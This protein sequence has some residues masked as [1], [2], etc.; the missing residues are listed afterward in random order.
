M[1]RYDFAS[2][3]AVVTG[4]AGGIGEQLAYAL[5]ERGSALILVDRDG[6]RLELVAKNARTR[7]RT[8]KSVR[9]TWSISR[10]TRRPTPRPRPSPPH[11]PTSAC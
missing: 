3:T 6:E 9:P 2:G 11:T 1:E 4:A 8:G 5:A 7:M 10:T